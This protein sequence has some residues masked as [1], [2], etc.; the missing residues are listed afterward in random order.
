MAGFDPR[1]RR[2]TDSDSFGQLPP[3]DSGHVPQPAQLRGQLLARVRLARNGIRGGRRRDRRALC[4][5]IHWNHDD[6]DRIIL[7]HASQ[8]SAGRNGNQGVWDRT[9][10]RTEELNHW[11]SRLA[12]DPDCRDGYGRGIVEWLR[13]SK[14]ADK[15]LIGFWG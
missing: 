10:E 8:D 11:E 4:R 1:Q 9:H 6:S 7:I 15:D 12:E 13:E 14:A 2:L 5:L 3:G